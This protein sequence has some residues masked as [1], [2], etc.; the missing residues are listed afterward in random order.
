M[1]PIRVGVNGAQGRMGSLSAEAVDRADDLD[2]VFTADRNDDLAVSIEKSGAEVVVD[3]TVP[4]AVFK[5]TMTVIQKGARPVVGTTGL[6]GEELEKIGK[7]IAEKKTGGIVAPNFSM[8]AVLMMKL[9]A[10]AANYYPDCEIIEMHH[11]RKIDA[12]SGTSILTAEKIRGGRKKGTRPTGNDSSEE[13]GSRGSVH[14]GTRV[15]SVR[16]PGRVAH[17]EVIFGGA[18]ESLLIR[19]DAVSRECF[20]PGLLLAIRRVVTLSA[21]EVGL[22]L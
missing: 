12:P 4:Q 19:H 9:A 13:K 1:N 18:G 8:G 22:R 10:E 6:T 14:H 16:L 21:L 5:N 17:Q 15:H 7:E 3:F 20:M 2:L 11:E